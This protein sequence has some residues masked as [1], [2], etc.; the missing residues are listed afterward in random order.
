MLHLYRS[1]LIIYICI[2]FVHCHLVGGAHADGGVAPRG[3]HGTSGDHC[4]PHPSAERAPCQCRRQTLAAQVI[5]SR[6]RAGALCGRV[7]SAECWLLNWFAFCERLASNST[8][9][10]LSCDRTARE[11]LANALALPVRAVQSAQ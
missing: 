5:A 11:R 1:E 8:A 7:A 4:A 9:S 10:T 2:S 6:L 3:G